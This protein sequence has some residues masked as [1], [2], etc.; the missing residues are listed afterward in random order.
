[1]QFI[2]KETFKKHIDGLLE[3][4]EIKAIA[5]TVEIDYQNI[6]SF[7]PMMSLMTIG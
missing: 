5:G 1:M 4:Y 6:R 2:E 3:E 7:P